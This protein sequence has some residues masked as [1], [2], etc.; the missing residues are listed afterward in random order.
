MR[1]DRSTASCNSQWQWC[2]SA[3]HLWLRHPD[4]CGDL[5]VESTPRVQES[6]PRHTHP[7]A[8]LHAAV[9][10]LSAFHFSRPRPS[11]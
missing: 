1:A 4:A 11:L 2:E 6:A 9:L 5:D 3:Q 8:L 7:H 10:E